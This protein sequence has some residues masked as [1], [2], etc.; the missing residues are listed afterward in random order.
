MPNS[1]CR[2]GCAYHLWRAKPAL[3]FAG[4]GVLYGRET[5]SQEGEAEAGVAVVVGADDCP[6]KNTVPSI[7]GF[8]RST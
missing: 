8:N 3:R 2:A 6:S 5:R 4:D 7:P 1:L